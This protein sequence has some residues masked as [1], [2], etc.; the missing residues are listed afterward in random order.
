[1][2]SSNT[3]CLALHK[4]LL[5]IRPKMVMRQK[6][7]RTIKTDQQHNYPSKPT[8]FPY[9]PTSFLPTPTGSLRPPE[10]QPK[11]KQN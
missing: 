3:S 5:L 10:G 11:D 4:H 2:N 1:M 8:R 6:K 7:A 9:Q